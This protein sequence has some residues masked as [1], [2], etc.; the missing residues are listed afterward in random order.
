MNE[1]GF[2]KRRGARAVGLLLSLAMLAGTAPPVWAQAPVSADASATIDGAVHDTRGLPLLGAFVAVIALGADRPAAIAVT[3]E[4]GEFHVDGLRQGVYSLLVG[5]LGFSGA[6]VQG[7]EVPSA[8]PIA[9]QLEPAT[10][11]ALSAFDAP[12]ELGYALRS[13]RRDILRQ[14]DAT[15]VTDDGR[16]GTAQAPQTERAWATPPT[17]A[18]MVGEFRVWSFTDVGE[19]DTVGVTSLS[20]NGT[21]GTVDTW[22]LQ[23]QVGDRGAVWA[24]SDAS[25]ELGAGHRMRVGF[26]YVGNSFEF[27]PRPEDDEHDSWIGSL[28]AEDRWQ[29]SEPLGVSIGVRYEHHNYLDASSLISPSVEVDYRPGE[30]TRLFTGIAYDAEGLDLVGSEDG[31]EIASLL[32]Q[33]N[34]RIGDTSL[35]EPQRT[36]HLELGVERQLG[37]GTRLRVQAYYDDVTD[38]L[39]GVY[40]AG[41]GGG[42]DYLLFNVGDASIRGFELALAAELLDRFS[43][44]VSY[45]Y[46]SRDGAGYPVRRVSDE[47]GTGALVGDQEYVETHE[48]EA[49]LT[50]VLPSF[51][52]HVLAI[53]NWKRGMPLMREGEVDNERGRFDLRLR[54]PLPFRALD[55][56]WSALVQVHNLLGPEYDSVFNVTLS[57]LLG[58]SRGIAGGLAVRF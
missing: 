38:E 50:T 57:E 14:T 24:H 9:L 53:Y 7:V 31:F 26:G 5:S 54:Q 48:V 11:R 33:S 43:G 42:N 40:V 28:H 6:M 45:V 1:S 19:H 20:L 4:R 8:Q 29:I 10:E 44:E 18:P 30:H 58:L 51:R 55:S 47:M 36:R 46:G 17:G 35:L 15:V 16:P 2:H 37:A 13:D 21:E 52:T 34:L 3:D 49:R 12:L 25:K 56:E 27:D 32:G 41:P 22:S 39:V 23:A